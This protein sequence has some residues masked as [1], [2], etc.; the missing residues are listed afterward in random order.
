MLFLREEAGF[1]TG[2]P[3]RL[4]EGA[5]LHQ[6]SDSSLHAA[7]ERLPRRKAGQWRRLS[8]P[9]RYTG[10][11]RIR[12]AR[13]DSIRGRAGEPA[14]SRQ[15]VERGSL[16]TLPSYST[17]C[18]FS[19]H[20]VHDCS[21]IVIPSFLMAPNNTTRLPEIL[22]RNENAL[23]QEW[24]NELLS[25]RQLRKNLVSEETLRGQTK[26]FLSAFR[27]AAEEGGF[28]E[29]DTPNWSRSRE[30]LG[31]IARSHAQLGVSPTEV[32]SFIFSLKRPVFQLLQK[33]G[34]GKSDL[35]LAE[36]W[37]VSHVLDRLGLFTTELAMK[38]RQDTIA[39][40]QAETPTG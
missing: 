37:R 36:I 25:G 28:D 3:A 11:T 19:G 10:P 1:R 16:G 38:S 2:G 15:S 31:D 33:E 5:P 18:H 7:G 4:P 21:I 27:Q 26:E 8:T 9:V 34:D 13:R 12:L 22:A 14:R 35:V 24:T 30:V 29:I 32:A 6:F 40:Q 23:L 20:P 17:P 39:R